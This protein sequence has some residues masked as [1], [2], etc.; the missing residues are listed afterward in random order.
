M[1]FVFRV[2][3]DLQIEASCYEGSWDG[4]L[5]FRTTFVDIANEVQSFSSKAKEDR[6]VMQS[7]RYCLEFSWAWCD[8]STKFGLIYL[9]DLS[10][11]SKSMCLTITN[12]CHGRSLKYPYHY[13]GIV[14]LHRLRG[15]IL[16]GGCCMTASIHSV[17]L[18]VCLADSILE[19]LALLFATTKNIHV[20]TSLRS[21]SERTLCCKILFDIW[22]G[23]CW[24]LHTRLGQVFLTV[25]ILI[26]CNEA[27]E[28]LWN[29]VY[30]LVFYVYFCKFG[31]AS[32]FI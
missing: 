15:F 22:I 27:S 21:L 30:S 8:R 1:L 32:A 4:M 25:A 28:P 13:M 20:N 3:F 26:A 24:G 16:Q 11:H 2:S 19:A 29:G 12:D 7:S 23:N 18:G 17:F 6:C 14:Y 5:I 31:K 10:P 9:Q